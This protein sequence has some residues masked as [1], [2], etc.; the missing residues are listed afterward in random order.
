MTV[1]IY[2][3]IVADENIPF[4]REAFGTLGEVTLRPG[5][6]LTAAQAAGAELLFV[7]SVTKVNAALLDG[8]RVRFVGSATA[9]TDHVDLDYVARR[10]L[11]FASAP[12][13]NANSVGEYMAAAWL[14]I[15]ARRGARLDGLRVGIIGA[16]NT[17]SRVEEK[18][19]ALGMAPVLND[20]PLA[21]QTG[22]PKYRPLGELFACDIVTCHTPLTHEGPDA[23]YHLADDEF[24][25]R[26]KPGAWFCNAGRGQ[27]VD[28]TAL[29]NAID[30]G[31][32]GAVVLDVWEQEP[33][34][35]ARLLEKVTVATPHVAGYSYDGKVRGTEMV[36]AA[37]C[38]FLGVEPRWTMQAALPP[39][40]NLIKVSA[41]G[42][43]PE[44]AY[45][46]KRS[47]VQATRS[48][49]TDE[50]ALHEIVSQLCPVE[51]DDE[52]LRQAITLTPD[53]RG[54]LFDRLRKEYPQ[55]REFPTAR[56][57]LEG[58][59]DALRAK[60]RALGFRLL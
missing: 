4:A 10:G 13:S 8:T 49:A 58:A 39:N 56:V 15:A 37:A 24:F 46:T 21:R 42:R 7:R 12:G 57:R 9:G 2:L 38:R 53:E 36:Y 59:S 1:P 28:T 43:A 20:P 40:S 11:G 25:E 45:A 33:R 31:R 17:G 18:A 27:V 50:G 16:G 54:T 48:V 22:D 3:K 41:T 5:R 26:L 35:S 23:T 32:L 60:V 30:S 47:F 29:L 19:R 14:T 44:A 55:R 52:A 6:S 51:R 34:V